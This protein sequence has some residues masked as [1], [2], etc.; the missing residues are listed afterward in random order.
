MPRNIKRERKFLLSLTGRLKG[1]GR[2]RRWYWMVG[3]S[4]HKLLRHGLG[5]WLMLIIYSLWRLS[6]AYHGLC[7]RACSK[8]NYSSPHISNAKVVLQFLNDLFTHKFLCIQPN[9]RITFFVTAQTAFHHCTFRFITGHCV[10]HC[11][12]KQALLLVLVLLLPLTADIVLSK[13]IVYAYWY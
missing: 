8:E 2:G 13:L 11:T 12:L 6:S 4:V 1:W 10:H 5:C 7:C 9:F 3:R